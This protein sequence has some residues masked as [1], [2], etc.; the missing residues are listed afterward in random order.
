MV[1]YKLRN[2]DKYPAGWHATIRLMA[3]R[4][5][6]EDNRESMGHV[7]EKRPTKQLIEIELR[8]TQAFRMNLRRHPLHPTSQIYNQ[9]TVRCHTQPGV[10][11]W[12]LVLTMTKPSK[13]DLAQQILT[14]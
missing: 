13:L 10:M 4:L 5:Q 9:F 3:A 2:P 7:I 8:R 11:G 14:A 12:E 6:I 1:M